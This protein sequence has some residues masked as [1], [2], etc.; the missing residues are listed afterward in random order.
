MGVWH[1][2][3]KYTKADWLQEKNALVQKSLD[4]TLKNQEISN[5]IAKAVEQSVGNIQIT[6]KTINQKAVHEITKEPVYT[7]CRTTPIGVQLIEDAIN[8]K[9]QSTRK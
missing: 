3:S 5:T 1:V 7:D 9:G 2:A 6:Q 4:V 8:N